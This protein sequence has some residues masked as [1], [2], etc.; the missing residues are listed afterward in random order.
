MVGLIIGSVIGGLLLL[1]ILTFILVY[2]SLT[3]AKNNSEKAFADI[4]VMLKKRYDLVPNLV[5]TVKG[6]AKHEKSLFTETVEL[7]NT[8]MT[9]ASTSEKVDINNKLSSNI[10]KVVALAENYPKL[11]ADSNFLSLQQSLTQIE[12][13]IATVRTNFND[14]TNIYN[15]KLDVFPNNLIAKIF[16]FNKISLFEIVDKKERENIKIEF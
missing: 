3:K 9:S 7:R 8:A 12:E 5:N 13:S 2:N 6:Y 16:K 4:D 10:G 11:Q 1:L 15:T 14:K